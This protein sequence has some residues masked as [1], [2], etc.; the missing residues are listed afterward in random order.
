MGS[1]AALWHP[2]LRHRIENDAT[3]RALVLDLAGQLRAARQAV[4][5][6][7]PVNPMPG[8]CLHCGMQEHCR[9]ARL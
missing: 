1:K 8:Q 5:Q 9:Q 7:I 4:Q 6:S 2:R 3:L